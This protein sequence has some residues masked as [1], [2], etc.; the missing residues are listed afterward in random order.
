[1]ENRPDAGFDDLDEVVT[2]SLWCQIEMV[3]AGGRSPR[4]VAHR[5]AETL[6]KLAT[7]TESGA[8][9]TGIVPILG[10]DGEKIGELS[11]DFYGEM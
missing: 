2:P 7:A 8:F 6:R 11:L 5:T 9:D 1:M 3:T 10:V 4:D